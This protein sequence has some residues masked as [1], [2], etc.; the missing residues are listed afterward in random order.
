[1]F[2]FD[3][4]SVRCRSSL[5]RPAK[6]IRAVGQRRSRRPAGPGAAAY[7]SRSVLRTSFSSRM[8]PRTARIRNM[9]MASGKRAPR[10]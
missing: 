6:T 9:G 1:M 3:T 10:L 8:I 7:L 2:G 5:S 4:A